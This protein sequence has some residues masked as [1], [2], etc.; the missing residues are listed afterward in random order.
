MPKVKARP[1]DTSMNAV[2]TA[3]PLFFKEMFDYREYLKQSV[4]RDLKNKYKRSMLGY[5]WTMLHPLAMMAVL[6]VVFSNIMRLSIQDYAI[7]L[8][9]GLLPWNFFSSTALM[10]LGSIRNNARLF[11]QVPL[12]KHIFVLSIAFSN[13]FNLLLA[14]LPLF[15]LT[16]LMGRNIPSTALFFP[17]LLLPL[18]CMV[19]G[20]SLLLAVCSVYFNDTLHL[21]EVALSALYFLSPI[22]YRREDLPAHLLQYITILNPFFSLIEGFH[23]IFY[24]GQL[25]GFD[26]LIAN[27]AAAL[28]MLLFGLYVFRRTE[29][30]FIYLL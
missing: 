23:G 16:L 24:Y 27:Y 20:I 19:V 13:A 6:A 12:P 14:L 17:V 30:K 25:P 26:V 5:L 28:L 1:Y 3:I 8:F 21:A 7:F 9:T 29:D 18:F 22:I 4:A 15:V 10:S 2:F 11:S